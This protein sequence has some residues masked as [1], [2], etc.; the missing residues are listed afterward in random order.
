MTELLLRELRYFFTALQF[1]T[2]IPIPAWVGYREEYLQGSRKY[3]PAIGLL[4]GFVSAL[5]YFTARLVLP[6]P[7]CLLLALTAGVLLTGAF[8]ED[9]FTD[10]CDGFGGGWKRDQILSIMKDSRIGSYGVVGLA[11]LL[12]LKFFALYEI[13]RVAEKALWAVFL[14][15]HALSRFLASTVVDALDHVDSAEAGQQVSK[16]KPLASLRLSLGERGYSFLFALAPLLFLPRLP[17]LV[18]FVLAY[19][20]RLHLGRFFRKWIDGYTGDCLGAVQ[21]VSETVFYLTLLGA[22]RFS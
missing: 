9:G 6:P 10:M 16:S 18:A 5:T 21:Q 11:L 19:L 14:S 20:S 7:L 17:A 13:A 12:A 4:V 2:R 15:G 22:W 8:H 3:F 1:F